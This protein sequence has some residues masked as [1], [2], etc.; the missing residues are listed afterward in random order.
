VV[1][2][3]KARWL[4]FLAALAGMSWLVG[5]FAVVGSLFYYSKLF[6]MAPRARGAVHTVEMNNHGKLFY[7][8]QT[9]ADLFHGLLLGGAA[10]SLV[11]LLLDRWLRSRATGPAD[12]PG[13]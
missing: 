12:K 13:V 11:S 9:E 8:S 4:E 10:L 5:L 1:R 6:D 7:V 2:S 3:Q